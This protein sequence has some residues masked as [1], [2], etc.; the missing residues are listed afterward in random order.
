LKSL[1]RVLVV[2]DYPGFRDWFSNAIRQI[3][4]L[5]VVGEASDGLEAVRKSQ[6]LHPDLILLD[7]GLPKLNGIE[8]TRWIRNLS[9]HAKILVVSEQRSRYIVDEALRFGAGGYLVKSDA[10][11]EI[12]LAV[13]SIL[14]GRQFVSTSAERGRLAEPADIGALQTGN[15]QNTLSNPGKRAVPACHHEASFYSDDQKLMEDLIPFIGIPLKAGS[16]AIVL[17]TESHRDQLLQRL[18]VYGL[19]IDAAIRQRRY[20]AL[21]AADTLSKFMSDGM[22]DRARFMNAFGALIEQARKCAGQRY[23]RVAV[24]GECVQV[25]LSRGNPEAAIQMEKAGNELLRKCNID[26]LCGYS[27]NGLEAAMDELIY[28]QICAEHTWV[29]SS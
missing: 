21:D 24:F 6:D 14:D 23:P 5:E 11:G 22:M 18:T 19:D 15:K 2:D 9:P 16:A 20:I 7:I 27:L 28:Q 26:I 29:H 3:E 17:A 4:G 10:A 13:E 12:R 1:I 8:V 25:L